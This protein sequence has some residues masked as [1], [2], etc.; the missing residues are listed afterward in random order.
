M[1]RSKTAAWLPRA[2]QCAAARRNS[3]NCEGCALL[4]WRP[5]MTTAPLLAAAEAAHFTDA[6][7]R[8]GALG[9]GRVRNLLV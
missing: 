1:L 8:C 9:E 6:L 7:R 4:W 3:R 2:Q 5:A